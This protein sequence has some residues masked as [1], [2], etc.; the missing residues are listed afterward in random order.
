VAP[1][2][3]PKAEPSTMPS[4]QPRTE[5]I[6]E[7]QAVPP[8][9]GMA[10]HNTRNRKQPE[11]YA[12]SITGNKYTVTLTQIAALLKGSKHAMS[13][14]MARMLVKLMSPGAHRRAGVVGMITA[15]LSMTHQQKMWL[16]S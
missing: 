5:P 10:A 14:S 13:M 15:Q 16:R 4:V 9:K 1:V 2:E 6:V 3:S 7:T 8:K 11:K 12:P